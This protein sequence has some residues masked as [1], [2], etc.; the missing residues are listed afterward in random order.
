MVTIWFD[1]G[2]KDREGVIRGNEPEGKW[3]YYYPDG[4]LD[5]IFD[6]GSGLE[7]VRISELENRDGIFYK[8]GKYKPYS[9]MVIE[10]GGIKDYLLLGRFQSGKKDGQ[11]V[12]WYRNGQKEGP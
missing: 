6:Y 9:G 4:E 3:S 5:F 1:N 8:I 11:W 12:Q 2:N 10:T 7:R